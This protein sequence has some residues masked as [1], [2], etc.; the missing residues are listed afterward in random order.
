MAG[1]SDAKA[2]WPWLV[3]CHFLFQRFADEFRHG[4]SA[5]GRHQPQPL[6]QVLRR[7]NRGATHDIIMACVP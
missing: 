6:Q 7:D 2:A 1:R 4:G 3:G 5:L